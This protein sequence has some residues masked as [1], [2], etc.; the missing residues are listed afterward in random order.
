VRK[1]LY[2]LVSLLA[3]ILLQLCL[4]FTFSRGAWLGLF[5]AFSLML[6]ITN[7]RKIIL[8]VFLIF[9]VGIILVPLLRERAMFTF[10]P[11][12]DKGR[13]IMWKGAWAMIEDNPFL[14]KGPGTF[15][16]YF[17]SYVKDLGISYAHNCYLQIWA[18]TG[19]F[20][21]F[22]FLLFVGSILA[23]G[24]K[25]SVTLSRKIFKD[26]SLAN[27][28]FENIH[29]ILFGLNCAIFG[30]LVHSFFDVHLYSLQL[31]V[32][33][34]VLLGI[35]VATINLINNSITNQENTR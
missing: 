3:I 35:L 32:L 7:K 29:R 26:S 33:F 15:M 25:I 14:G 24:I 16:K 30:F 5:A 10:L 17:P 6:L 11:E 28:P 23:M 18:E 13:F 27:T 34:W 12:G 1:L 4:L 9:V 19:I 21:L 22:C 8:F 20:S 2:F 31:A